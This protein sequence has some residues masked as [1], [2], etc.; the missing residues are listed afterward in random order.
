MS[1]KLLTPVTYEDT[2]DELNVV[3]PLVLVDEAKVELDVPILNR[4]PVS[5]N[6]PAIGKL[7]KCDIN[8]C[9]LSSP[10]GVI[11][12]YE[13]DEVYDVPPGDAVATIDFGRIVNRFRVKGIWFIAETVLWWCTS[14]GDK[15]L[16]I[17]E[18]VWAQINARGRYF[19]FRLYPYR[20][21]DFSLSLYGYYN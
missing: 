21:E 18:N 9:A 6:R 8:G 3:R 14:S 20:G 15:L 16:E 12:K 17:D 7:L 1:R 2:L 10:N 4:N 11:D 13:T 19:K 5:E